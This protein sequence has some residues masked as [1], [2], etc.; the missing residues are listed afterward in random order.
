MFKVH[1]HSKYPDYLAIV[2]LYQAGQKD[3]TAIELWQVIDVI[4]TCC[5]CKGEYPIQFVVKNKYLRGDFA[6]D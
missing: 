4:Y 5:I 2:V 6:F 3:V 1:E